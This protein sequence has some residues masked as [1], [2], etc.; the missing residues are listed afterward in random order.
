MLYGKSEGTF[1]KSMA[2]EKPTVNS[3][4]FNFD[5]VHIVHCTMHIYD[6]ISKLKKKLEKEVCG[7]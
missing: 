5:D 1:L 3:Y 7:L 6:F 4:D 2:Y